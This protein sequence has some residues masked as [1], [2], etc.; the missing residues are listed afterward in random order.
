MRF[1]DGTQAAVT[2]TPARDDF[3]FAN[4]TAG[5]HYLSGFDAAQDLVTFSAGLFA[6]F[7]A[8]RADDVAY[9]GGTFIAIGQNAGLILQGVTPGQLTSGNFAFV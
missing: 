4:F 3:G 8:L 9:Q 2:V 7:A 1:I 6:N 5:L